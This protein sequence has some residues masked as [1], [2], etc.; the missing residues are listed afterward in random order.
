MIIRVEDITERINSVAEKGCVFPRFISKLSYLAVF[1]VAGYQVLKYRKRRFG[2][3]AALLFIALLVAYLFQN[4][5]TFDTVTSYIMF[6]FVLAFLD[7]NFQKKPTEKSTIEMKAKNGSIL[8]R[9]KRISSFVSF[10]RKKSSPEKSPNPW[11]K[12]GAPVLLIIGAVFI[13][14]TANIQPFQ[15]N[16]SL[17]YA[18]RTLGA[19]ELDKAVTTIEKGLNSNEFLRTEM[20]YYSTE[21]VFFAQRLAQYR[22]PVSSK[23]IVESLERSTGVL[24][25]SLAAQPEIL[26]MRG[27]LL[28]VRVY[29]TLSATTND[30]EYLDRAERTIG[31]ALRLNPEFPVLYR[32]AGKIRFLQ[33][34]EE[35][36]LVFFSKAYEL[37][38]DLEVSYQWIG[39][40]FIETGRFEQGTDALRKSLRIGEFYTESYFNLEKVWS[41]G[42][43]YEQ[44]G[45]YTGMAEF[46]EEVISRSPVPPHPQLFAS[47]AQVYMTMGD[48]EKARETTER[49]F[50]LYPE[51]R[52]QAEEFLKIL[53][54]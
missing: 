43:L 19:G 36:G 49:M 3:F 33:D 24:E 2:T 35:E 1:V 30:Q 45:N 21:M 14:W 7:A 51:T 15:T 40:S 28:L 31:N 5:V 17:A 48:K 20:A 38:N 18:H 37:D 4:I 34:R 11:V 26:E 52:S 39:E 23:I 42:G 50:E 16:L 44:S 32:L 46:Y 10:A 27:Y 25:Q 6:F 12:K 47:L 29:I 13:I 54:E 22:D 53:D 9:L 41:L 8:N